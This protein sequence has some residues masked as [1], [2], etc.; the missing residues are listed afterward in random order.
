[1]RWTLHRQPPEVLGY[2]H[3]STLAAFNQNIAV[4]ID[5]DMDFSVAGTLTGVPI[6][7][8]IVRFKN[9]DLKARNKFIAELQILVDDYS[10]KNNL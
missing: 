4:N 7:N 3:K 5:A 10:D 8:L 6:A 9:G 2:E 1:M